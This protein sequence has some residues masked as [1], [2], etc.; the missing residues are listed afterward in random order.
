MGAASAEVSSVQ[1]T[2]YVGSQQLTK[3]T[4][5]HREEEEEVAVVPLGLCGQGFAGVVDAVTVATPAQMGD[6]G[7][8][9]VKE[10]IMK[11]NAKNFTLHGKLIAEKTVH[12]RALPDNVCLQ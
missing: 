9:M 10:V 4:G 3:S 12:V 7:T 2:H 5:A 8:A 1:P 11:K 6:D